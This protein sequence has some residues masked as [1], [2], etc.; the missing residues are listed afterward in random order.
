M[1]SG[2]EAGADEVLSA[3]Y[4]QYDEGDGRVSLENVSSLLLDLQ[5]RCA[6]FIFFHFFP[7][8][9]QSNAKEKD[10]ILGFLSNQSGFVSYI[11]DLFSTRRFNFFGMISLA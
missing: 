9:I 10:I 1:V 7:K 6:L 3:I 11:C 8:M 2:N 4:A 5:E